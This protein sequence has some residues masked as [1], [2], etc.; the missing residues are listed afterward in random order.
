MFHKAEDGRPKL[1]T[2]SFVNL[3]HREIFRVN[4]ISWGETRLCLG[5]LQRFSWQDLYNP[6]LDPAVLLV[7]LW[8]HRQDFP[9]DLEGRQEQEG[10][11]TA[12]CQES[13]ANAT[14]NF[15]ESLPS[16]H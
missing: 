1:P 14:E 15:R 8:S 16:S 7:L 4:M 6:S 5:S 9:I 10:R 11:S 13:E 12:C 2:E 3:E